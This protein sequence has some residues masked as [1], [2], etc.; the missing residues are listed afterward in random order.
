[1]NAL[2]NRGDGIEV[3]GNANTIGGGWE[4]EGNV[5]SGNNKNG[6]KLVGGNNN[7]VFGNFI[8]TEKNGT[9][10]LGNGMNGIAITTND[11]V[12]GGAPMVVAGD[13]WAP[14]NV[15]SANAQDGV[16]L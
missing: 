7:S 16:F 9:T 13:V 8:G 5:I 10:A 12:I 6:V 4:N 3:N 1:Q 11:S 2:A 14:G 15:I